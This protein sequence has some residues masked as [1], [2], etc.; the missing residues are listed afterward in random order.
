M[1][2]KVMCKIKMERKIGSEILSK[3]F[4]STFVQN[5][6]LPHS[7]KIF[8]FHRYLAKITKTHSKY[9]NQDK[10]KVEEMENG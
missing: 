2:H 6:S 9:R 3:Y 1:K 8:H 7:F 5:I 4:T 10:T